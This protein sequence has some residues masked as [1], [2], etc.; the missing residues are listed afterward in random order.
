[1]SNPGNTPYQFEA[2][3]PLQTGGL[4]K[5][6]PCLPSQQQKTDLSDENSIL[7]LNPFLMLE[8][9]GPSFGVPQYYPAYSGVVNQAPSQ[10]QF[11]YL[12]QPPFNS[13]PLP[14]GSSGILSVQP[15]Y[16]LPSPPPP[17]GSQVQLGVS[18]I[19]SSFPSTTFNIHGPA[20]P[21]SF[22]L[23]DTV[24]SKTES[25]SHQEGGGFGAG[26][27]QAEANPLDAVRS[28]LEKV[29]VNPKDDAAVRCLCCGGS[30]SLLSFSLSSTPISYRGQ[31]ITPVKHL[32]GTTLSGLLFVCEILIYLFETFLLHLS[33]FPF[34]LFPSLS[35]CL[36]LFLSISSLSHFL[37]ICSF[38]APLFC[39][40]ICCCLDWCYLVVYAAL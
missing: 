16:I 25:A 32:I 7:P 12:L 38:S 34:L 6:P 15:N 29:K 9:Q 19:P 26:S 1:M 14:P 4:G 31:S 33:L 17:L 36:L 40:C 39:L 11:P 30:D 20:P 5:S 35:F 23:G 37:S 10:A 8:N 24:T 3:N 21:V 13:R 27:G 2:N 18:S 28:A 22:H